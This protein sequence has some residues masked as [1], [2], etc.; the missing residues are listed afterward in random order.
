[1][2]QMNHFKYSL[3]NRIIVEAIYLMVNIEN[4]AV[5]QRA[6]QLNQKLKAS[7]IV[8]LAIKISLNFHLKNFYKFLRDI[9]KLPHVIS[10]VASLKLP[11]LRKSVLRVFS[12][13]YNSSILNVPVDFIKSLLIYDEMETLLQDLRNLG[14]QVVNEENPMKVV[15]N[16]SKFDPNKS[17]VS[18]YEY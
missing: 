5:L 3:E 15:F 14:I 7:F 1:M 13:A 9:Q 8:H 17:I 2:D 6:V 10:A 4:P 11:H 16:R 12:I 18:D